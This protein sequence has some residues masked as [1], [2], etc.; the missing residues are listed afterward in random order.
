[1]VDTEV[2]QVVNIVCSMGERRLISADEMSELLDLVGEWFK[3]RGVWRSFMLSSAPSLEMKAQVL[4]CRL[5][6]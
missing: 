3:E 6:P 4:K 1:M 2:D 5:R